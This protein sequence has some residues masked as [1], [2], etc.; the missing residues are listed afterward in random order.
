M[1][2]KAMDW[3]KVEWKGYYPITTAQGR[4]EADS[5]GI[6]AIYELGTKQPK[7]LLYVGETYTQSFGKRL[8]QHQRDWLPKYDDRKLAIAFGS[9][10]LPEGKKIS[11]AIVFDVEGVLIHNQIPPCNTSG[12]KGY[13]GR[14]GIIVINVGKNGLLPS[15]VTDDKELLSL[16]RKHL[17]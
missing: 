4:P 14:E 17:A 12:K 2:V 3:F 9:I 13:Q 16:L 7:K 15:V 8:K 11:Q 6:Y 1:E 10:C 5:Y